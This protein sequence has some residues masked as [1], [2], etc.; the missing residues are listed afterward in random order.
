MLG[1]RV[2][3]FQRLK[4]LREIPVAFEL[5]G[6]HIRPLPDQPQGPRR[7]RAVEDPPGPELDLR[8]VPAVF[9]VEMR[10]WWS[11]R[12]IQITIP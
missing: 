8:N 5:L 9:R 1:E 2:D 3:R 11:G 4:R 6:V 12:Y 7:Q 10:R